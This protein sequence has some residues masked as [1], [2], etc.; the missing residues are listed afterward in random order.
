[1]NVLK[2]SYNNKTPRIQVWNYRFLCFL[3]LKTNSLVGGGNWKS[4]ILL[5]FGIVFAH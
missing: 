5:K 3:Y 2:L 4:T 1:M